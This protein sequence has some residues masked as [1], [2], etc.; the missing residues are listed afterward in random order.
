MLEEEMIDL[1]TFCLQNDPDAKQNPDKKTHVHEIGQNY[2]L[3]EEQ[4]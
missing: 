1:P 3:M 2:S 4:M